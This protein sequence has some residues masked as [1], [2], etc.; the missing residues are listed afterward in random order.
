MI[1]DIQY[2][3]SGFAVR[4]ALIVAILIGLGVWLR[5]SLKRL[6]AGSDTDS[7]ELHPNDKDVANE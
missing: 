2:Y 5:K 7:N 4:V 1:I 6:S 3:D